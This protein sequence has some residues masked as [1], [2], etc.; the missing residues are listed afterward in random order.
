[1][2]VRVVSLDSLCRRQIHVSV[3]CAWQIPAH[4]I[5]VFGAGRFDTICKAVCDCRDS[6][7][8]VSFGAW[9]CLL[10]FSQC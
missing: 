7:T 9:C 8:T 3:Y 2:Y 6:S 10:F 5:F 1:M 4:L